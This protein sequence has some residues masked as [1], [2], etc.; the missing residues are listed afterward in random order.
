MKL[1][2]YIHIPD[3][4]NEK[5]QKNTNKTVT[6]LSYETSLEEK[7]KQPHITQIHLFATV[8]YT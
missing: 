6:K 8:H 1:C 2:N 7:Q 4:K 3:T 5:H